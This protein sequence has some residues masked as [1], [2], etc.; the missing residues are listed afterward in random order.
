VRRY[1]FTRATLAAGD[2]PAVRVVTQG[3]AWGASVMI[4]AFADLTPDRADELADELRRLAA[5]VRLNA[6]RS[7]NG[8]D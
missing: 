6:R 2:V 7:T 8:P 5:A 1:A 3:H 4:S